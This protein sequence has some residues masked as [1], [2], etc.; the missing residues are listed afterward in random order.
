MTCLTPSAPF[1]CLNTALVADI[2]KAMQDDSIHCD[3]YS[4]TDGQE[5][6]CLQVLKGGVWVAIMGIW[7]VR[8]AVQSIDLVIE[9]RMSHRHHM[10][11]VRGCSVVFS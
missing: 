2:L 11:I 1:P 7:T 5:A 3:G 10:R 9:S 8:E 4:F 6:D